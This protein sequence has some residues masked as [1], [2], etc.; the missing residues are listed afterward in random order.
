M[1]V[2][3]AVYGAAP[4]LITGV[5][6]YIII[7]RTSIFKS[8]QKAVEKAKAEIAKGAASIAADSES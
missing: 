1:A 5:I 8:D 3:L 4:G 6:F 2:A 7:E